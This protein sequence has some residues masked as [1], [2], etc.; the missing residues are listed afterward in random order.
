[1]YGK[2]DDERKRFRKICFHKVFL[3]LLFF[4]H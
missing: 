4:Y 2:E 1:M 3:F